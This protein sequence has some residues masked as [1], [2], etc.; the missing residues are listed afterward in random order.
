MEELQRVVGEKENSKEASIRAA[1]ADISA[2]LQIV[3]TRD[4]ESTNKLQTCL[5]KL[6]KYKSQYSLLKSRYERATTDLHHQVEVTHSVLVR[7]RIN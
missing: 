2:Q 1:V 3:Q 6:S 5:K 4:R 7:T